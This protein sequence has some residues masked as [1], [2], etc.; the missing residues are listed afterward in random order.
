MDWFDPGIAFRTDNGPFKAAMQKFTMKIVS[1]MKGEKLYHG[2]GG[3]IILS[4]AKEERLH[5][6][7]AAYGNQRA[8]KAEA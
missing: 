3:P 6:R 2:Q 4:Q 7:F 5:P 8:G 1:M